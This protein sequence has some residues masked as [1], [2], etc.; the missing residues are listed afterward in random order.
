MRF[1]DTILGSVRL[2]KLNHTLRRAESKNRF[3]L[4]DELLT[5]LIRMR[6]HSTSGDWIGRVKRQCT[7]PQSRGST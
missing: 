4:D 1:M 5:S 6:I 7:Q 2:Q 3:R